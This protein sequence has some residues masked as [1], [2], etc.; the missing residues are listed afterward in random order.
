MTNSGFSYETSLLLPP[1]ICKTY[2]AF[3]EGTLLDLTV[4]HVDSHIVDASSKSKASTIS[5]TEDS[6]GVANAIVFRSV[7]LTTVMCFS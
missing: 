3:L 5:W 4:A 7:T 1:R 2:R 6:V